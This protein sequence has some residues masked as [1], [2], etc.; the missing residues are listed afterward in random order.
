MWTDS[1]YYVHIFTLFCVCFPNVEE[2]P[3]LMNYCCVRV[4]EYLIGHNVYWQ[5][6]SAFNS[7]MKMGISL[8][9][10]ASTDSFNM[11][12]YP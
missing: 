3:S 9:L 1:I 12:P 8:F 10:I 7:F 2:R 4:Q 11:W 6:L 5:A